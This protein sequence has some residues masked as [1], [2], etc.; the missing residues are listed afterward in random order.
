MKNFW[1]GFRIW[2]VAVVMNTLLYAVFVAF[3][4]NL[5]LSILMLLF[6]GFLALVFTLPVLTVITPIV[7]ITGKIPNSINAK[8]VWLTALLLLL[9]NLYLLGLEW[10]LP[11]ISGGN[12]YLVEVLHASVSIAIILSVLF[13]RSS[14]IGLY[15][16]KN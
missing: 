12:Y 3:T 2:V 7:D 10:F 15:N 16:K 5:L 6:F 4:G 8:I 11:L 14:L 13:S 9:G 1:I